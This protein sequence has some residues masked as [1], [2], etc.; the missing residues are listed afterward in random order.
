MDGL[1]SLIWFITSIGPQPPMTWPVLTTTHHD[2]H[3]PSQLCTTLAMMAAP[4]VATRWLHQRSSSLRMPWKIC[5]SGDHNLMAVIGAFQALEIPWNP[6]HGF[7]SSEGI[8]QN[9][10][11]HVPASEDQTHP[12]AEGHLDHLEPGGI[13]GIWAMLDLPA[14]GGAEHKASCQKRDFASST[15]PGGSTWDLAYPMMIWWKIPG[16]T[17]LLYV[18]M[19]AVNGFRLCWY[20]WPLKFWSESWKDPKNCRRIDDEVGGTSIDQRSDRWPSTLVITGR[21][22]QITLW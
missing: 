8:L 20:T 16:E 7:S 22:R 10:P 21:P 6:G 1:I 18:T 11:Q 15:R 4:K 19:V 9:L 12:T 3:G 14:A 13:H 17:K 5:R 2:H